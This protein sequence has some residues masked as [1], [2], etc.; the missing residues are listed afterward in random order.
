MNKMH[1]KAKQLRDKAE[2]E[3]IK[4]L[5]KTDPKV[6]EALEYAIDRNAIVDTAR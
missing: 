4:L 5:I 1:H 2:M 6:R 3:A